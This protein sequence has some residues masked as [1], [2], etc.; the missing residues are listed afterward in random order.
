MMFYINARGYI[1][2]DFRYVKL[3][4]IIRTGEYFERS[5]S[6]FKK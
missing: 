4:K 5:T 1:N 2:K 6:N 3:I